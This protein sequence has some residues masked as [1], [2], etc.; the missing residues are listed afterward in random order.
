MWIRPNACHRARPALRISFCFVRSLILLLVAL[1]PCRTGA[2]AV[3]GEPLILRI[4]VNQVEKGDF[5]VRR[6]KDGDFLVAVQD[7]E[8]MGFPS[9]SGAVTR[10]EGEAYLSLRSLKDVDFTFDETTLSLIL[11]AKPVMLGREV[12]DFESRRAK[13]VYYPRDASLFLNYG[14]SYRAGEGLS[15]T[16]FNLTNE[17]GL[18]TGDVLFLSDSVFSQDQDQ[19][20]FTRLQSRFIYDDRR[21]L[22]RLMVGDFFAS[23]GDLGGSLNL[24]GISFR[25]VY[26]MDPYQVY[27]PTLNLTGQAAVPSEA[28]IYLNGMLIRTEKLSPG[29]FELKNLTPYSAAGSIDVVLR[30]AFGR[31]QMLHYPFYYADDSLLKEGYHEYSYNVGLTRE[32]YGTRGNR[33]GRL[34]FSAFH[35]Y[36]VSDNFTLGGH[37]EADS[38]GGNLGPQLTF[39][40]G[41]AGMVSLSL[42]GSA[43]DGSTGGAGMMTYTFRGRH[44]GAGFSLAGY[45]RHYATV[46]DEKTDDKTRLAASARLSY[47][48]RRLG[49]LA[50]DVSAMR[51][52]S[53]DDRDQA[54]LSYTRS[55]GRGMSLT[56]TWRRIREDDYANE[57]LLSLNYTPLR[58]LFVSSR[59]EKTEDGDEAAI[60]VQKNPPVGEGLSY[61][62]S[63]KRSRA[64]GVTTWTVDPHVQYNGRYGIY[65]ASFESQ[66]NGD[67]RDSRYH[68]SV[69]GSLVHVGR[70][71]G[72]TRPVN[73]SFGL[74]QVGSVEGIKVRVNSEEVGVTDASGRLF[75][76]D[77]SS[78]N[79]NQ[80]SIEA[81]DLPM[82]YQFSSVKRLVSP[83]LRSGSCI[84][85]V[86]QR[87]QPIFGQLAMRI[88]GEVKPVEFM[89]IAL[90]VNG[91]IFTF[92]T[93]S[94]GEFDIDLT[95]SDAF[96]KMLA[97]QESGCFAADDNMGGA[98]KPGTYQA[99]FR[100]E[101]RRR[102]FA[103]TIPA[104]ED[105]FI[106]LGQIIIEDNP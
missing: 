77:L 66:M 95:Q 64:D 65:E 99:S 22:R 20:T 96:K 34:L 86:I 85:F 16:S 9:P 13:Q 7:L 84:P 78:Y 60:S 17:L 48:T 28:K 37:A 45:T 82:D 29:E 19:E 63:V 51:R 14:A 67:E 74:V 43:G 68:L 23:S 93:G 58:K 11:D 15:F 61:R 4:V 25:K 75:V 54:A 24:G 3:D 32:D 41:R 21:S 69:A 76:P 81:G 52:Y 94:G 18:R 103:L 5:F 98:L 47:G 105:P 40:A 71:F 70:A 35:R 100:Y 79:N 38:H 26:R 2:V 101:G 80:V 30:D 50:L 8:Q 57:F 44:F 106:D 12:I 97:A 46:A 83:P 89:E 59:Y 92:P 73:D 1:H 53:G 104:C 10:V 33:Y 72:A 90:D 87:M 39:V 49:T 27:Y 88:D 62:A 55:L 36:G 56:A 42:A 6:L 102:P 91:A 31:E